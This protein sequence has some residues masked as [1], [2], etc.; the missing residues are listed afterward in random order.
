MEG[1]ETSLRGS[2]QLEYETTPSQPSSSNQIT[3]LPE[4]VQDSS[5][6]S[7]TQQPPLQSVPT[8]A[9]EVGVASRVSHGLEE[10]EKLKTDMASVWGM[11][12]EAEPAC[13]PL[14]T[15]TPSHSDTGG[16]S[17]SQDNME[18]NS[19]LTS[20]PSDNHHSPPHTDNNHTITPS[21]TQ[22]PP[23]DNKPSVANDPVAMET[24]DPTAQTN[25]QINSSGA[26]AMDTEQVVSPWFSLTPRSPCETKPT[27]ATT[28]ALP[29]GIA[30]G[31]LQLVATAAGN[32][33]VQSGGVM[34][35]Y[36]TPSG[37]LAAAPAQMGYALVGNTLVPQQYLATA[38]AQ[39]PYII[40]QGGVQYV[41]G[42]GAGGLIG[43]GGVAVMPQP[44]GGGASGLVGAVGEGGAVLQAVGDSGSV[45]M[46]P[47]DTVAVGDGVRSASGDGV[48]G[49]RGVADE[50][51]VHSSH[52]P[53][54]AQQ[55]DHNKPQ[56]DIQMTKPI[57]PLATNG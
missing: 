8:T 27:V 38:A 41:V 39:Q 57:S 36:I 21:H 45:V 28:M 35:Y 15:G 14:T 50:V 52:R 30:E 56:T 24:D 51:K 4:A 17:H 37:A 5:L 26:V 47:G 40:S 11:S 19:G 53:E 42:G 32:Q 16:Q 18:W 43:L 33:L 13:H 23:P 6:H 2:G 34:Q 55:E 12:R 48:R 46:A 44:A 54:L 25:V 49:T 9:N 1:M 3:A 22:S 10:V 31:Q 20:Q 29:N 7:T